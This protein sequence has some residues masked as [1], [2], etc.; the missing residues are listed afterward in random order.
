[1]SGAASASTTANASGNYTF[2]GLANGSYTVTPSKSGFTFSPLNQA[3][4]INS[5]NMGAVNFTASAATGIT[6]DATAFGDRTTKAT[7]VAT[8]P[9][10]STTS[11]NEL[12]L[13]MVGADVSTSSGTNNS[14]TSVTGAGLTWVLVRRTNTQRGTAE[15][16]RAFATA[17][18]TNVT[19]TA[20]LAI[21][22]VSSVTVM[23][24]RGVNTSGT[25]GSGAIGNTGT[26]NGTTGAPT[27][28]LVT[29]GSN[30]LVVGVGEDWNAAPSVTAGSN[31]TV[32]HQ[33]AVPNLATFW[34]QRQNAT[35][36]AIGTTVTINDTV[37]TNHQFN[38]TICEILAA[39]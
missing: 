17:P 6:I 1:L 20:N 24:F 12:L 9:A 16:W 36:P 4:T 35:T 15:I 18:L 26:G 21:S 22:A 38:F 19:V 8:S 33:L 29:L 14:V 2:T 39:P 11:A 32:V 31:Q 7:T 23:S 34:A 25:S 10:F 37:P 27:A 13:A 5:A 30:S 3:V 28:S